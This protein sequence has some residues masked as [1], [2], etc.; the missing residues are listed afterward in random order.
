[1]SDETKQAV[2]DAARRFTA[3]AQS[4]DELDAALEAHKKDEAKPAAK[5]SAAKANAGE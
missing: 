4:T 5:K 2:Y 3:D 1:M